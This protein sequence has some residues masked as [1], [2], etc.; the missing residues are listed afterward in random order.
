MA[1]ADDLQNFLETRLLALDPTIDLSPSSPAQTEVIGPT[2]SR[3]SDDPFVTDI[4]AFI[5]DRMLQEYPDL[6]ADNGGLLED[7]LTKPLQMLLEPFKREIALTRLGQSAQNAS[8]MSDDEADAL[9]ANWFESR[10]EG[11]TSSGGVRLY[12][13]APSTV[14]VTTDK[15]VYTAAGLAFYPAQN[16]FITSAQMLYNRQ[17][18][19]YFL[20]IVVQAE[21]A[22]SEYNVKKG[23]IIGIDSLPNVINVSNL[24]DFVDGAPRENN[25]TYLGSFDQVLTER[26]LVTKR[27]ILVRTPKLYESVRALQVIGAGQEGM[28]RDI[29]TGTGEGLL[30]IAGTGA[31]FG[32]WLWIGTVVYKYDGVDHTIIPQAGDTVRVH[33][34]SGTNPPVKEAVVASV[35]AAG[36]GKYL[37]LLNSA[38]FSTVATVVVDYALLKPG[39]LTISGVPGGI[40]ANITVPNKT[41]HLGGHTDIFVRPTADAEVQDSLSNLTDDSPIMALTDMQVPTATDNDIKSYYMVIA[42][43]SFASHGVQFGDTLVVETGAGF[44]GTYRILEVDSPTVG[45]LRLDAIFNTA[46]APGTF[47]RAR[48]VRNINVDLVAPRVKK[49]PFGS[50][51]VSDLQ[52]SVGSNDFTFSSTNLQTYGAVIGDVVKILEG[53]DAGEYVITAF[54]V[55]LGGQ[56]VTVDRIVSATGAG[57]KYEVYTSLKGLDFPLVRLKSVEVLD[58]TG[59]GTGIT[60]PY[61]DAVDI[62]PI[63]NFEGAGNEIVVLD[64]SL[65]V[66]PDLFGLWSALPADPIPLGTI[67]Q[68]SDAKYTQGIAPLGPGEVIRRVFHS[69]SDQIHVSEIAVPTFMSNGVRDTVLALCS[70]KDPFFASTGDNQTSD[71]AE[72]KVGDTFSISDG[73]NQG[74]Y[75]ILEHRILDLWAKNVPVGHRKVALLRVDPPFKTDPLRTAINFTMSATAPHT[76]TASEL[77]GFLQYAADWDNSG[78]FYQEVINNLQIALASEGIVFSTA[79][80]NAALKAFMDP[81]FRSGYTVGPAARGDFR[82]YFLEPV[83]AEFNF[84]D[85]PTTFTSASDSSKMFRLAPNIPSAQIL[86]ESE[87][88]TP[89]VQWNRNLAMRYSQDVNIWLTSGDPLAKRGVRAGDLLEFR[90]AINDFPSRGYMSSS[91]L[92]ATQVG[93]NVVQ[94]LVPKSTTG[95]GVNNYTTIVPGQLL[96]LD[97]GPDIGAYTITSVI[98]QTWGIDQPVVQVQVDR[99]MSH[100]TLDIPAGTDL[101][102]LSGLPAYVATS[103]NV[104]PMTVT[105]L[106]IKIGKSSDG[107]LTWSDVENT[108]ISDFT[109]ATDAVTKLT[110]LFGG[111]VTWE[112]IGNEICCTHP[113]QGPLTRIVVEAPSSSSAYGVLKFTVGDSGTGFQGA[114]AL[115]NTKRIYGSGLSVFS[116]GDW[117]TIYAASQGGLFSDGQDAP[118]LGTFQV[119]SI[120][121]DFVSQWSTYANWI[122]LDR[123]SS[124]PA[125]VDVTVR[126]VRHG[127]AAPVSAPADTSGGGKEISDQFVRFR[128]YESVSEQRTVAAIPWISGSNSPLLSSSQLQ[129]QLDL[130]ITTSGWGHMMPYRFIRDGVHRVSSTAM[131][132]R[133]EGALYYVDLPV[134]GYG[135]RSEMNVT[136]AEGF[137]LSGVSKIEGYTLRVTDENFAYSVQEGLYIILPGSVLPVGSTPELGNEFNLAGQTVQVTYNNAPL[138]ADLQR[139]YDSPLDRVTAASMLARHFLPA[140]V[141]LD[142]S[143]IG[144]AAESD[145][146]TEII[147][148][149]NNIDPDVAELRADFI[150]DIIKRKS[151]T[152]VNLPFTLIALVHGTDRRIRGM[153]SQTLIGAADVPFFKGT[154]NQSYFIAGPDTSKISPRPAGEQVFLKRS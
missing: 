70:R 78:G 7:I 108:F 99:V 30:H 154:F 112:A 20:D 145:V 142:V 22:G 121:A 144:G 134:L 28:N 137:M 97:S 106:K 9:G 64:K 23:D 146:A 40:S 133:R 55:S 81:L 4:P 126:W 12:F 96:F 135:P 107:G 50:G 35:L 26:S 41:V 75:L 131:A 16:Y 13:S 90:R 11:K 51:T 116:V 25:E 138:V 87:E 151:A 14:R 21:K 80:S 32:D 117:V 153:R 95:T 150:Q 66:M 86:P 54:S 2:L 47:L 140:Y 42:D 19:L 139:F 61:G 29:L 6:A 147:N 8:L 125:G 1:F 88:W 79:N 27:G 37:L 17:G 56:G 92:A 57:L 128:M 48:I 71:L 149:I 102:F 63:A 83:S 91:W 84:K 94:L 38:P 104:F 114:A 113:N 105:G 33:A 46:T 31:V 111:F 85:N 100:T 110:S 148:Y 98:S 123:S 93:S 101:D 69:G 129:A 122:E 120:G 67:D 143:Y 132:N 130:V 36:S 24:S 60:V 127:S 152:K 18:S 76:W 103:G 72:A 89:A 5:K 49:L 39:Y 65:I 118:Y 141:F 119:I 68:H 58:S 109:D 3:F 62:R 52:T 136:Q 15:R 74:Q 44:A 124:F 10:D 115:H 73:P 59:Q 82:L 77:F 45:H 43:E 53:P 34:T